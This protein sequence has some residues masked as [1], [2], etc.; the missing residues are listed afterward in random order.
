MGTDSGPRLAI[1]ISGGGSTMVNLADRIAGGRLAA[2]IVLVVS[3][4]ATAEGNR[5]ALERGLPVEVVTGWTDPA[6]AS[7][8]AFDLIRKAG[9]DVVVCGGFLKRLVVPADF[10]GR[11]VNIHPSLIPSFCGPGMFGLKVHAAALARGVK[12]SGCTVHLVD[13]E[14]DHGPILAQRSVPV[15]SGDT[16]EILQSRVMQAEREL[17]PEVIADWKRT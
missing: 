8:R 14:Y 7:A 3:S 15:L 12:L 1:L 16:P 13:D 4:S 10:T 2:R 5:R 17:L 9:A 11:V 6:A